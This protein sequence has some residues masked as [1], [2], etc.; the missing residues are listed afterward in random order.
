MRRSDSSSAARASGDCSRRP[1]S[2]SSAAIVCRLFFTRWWI[3][4]IV[5][6]F[7]SS[8]RSRRRRSVTSRSSTSTPTI[9]SPLEQRDRLHQHRRVALLDLLGDGQPG[10]ASRRRPRPGR[11]P[12]PRGAAPTCTSGCPCGAASSPRSGSRT[13]PAGRGRATITPS[14]TRGASS[15]SSSSWRNGKVPSAIMRGEAVEHREVVVLELTEPAA[16]RRARLACDHRDHRVAG[17]HR[18]AL[19]VRPLGRRRA[20]ARRPRR[21][22]R[23]RNAAADERARDLVDH[24]SHE[25]HRVDGLA[26]RGP[27][28]GEDHRTGDPAPPRPARAAGGRR[29]RGRRAA[30]TTPR[31]AARAAAPRPRAR[32][33]CGPARRTWSR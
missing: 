30:A 31:A 26:G 18:D 27:D 6:S 8:S 28:L 14:P 24:R 10:A 22:R 2:R 20:A 4:R 29:S 15:N 25:V 5:A 17:A 11:S 16:E 32:S 12:S 7:D 23:S 19:H 13:A 21:S 9:S 33:S 1:C 3:S